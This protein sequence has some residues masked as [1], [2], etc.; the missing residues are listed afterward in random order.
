MEWQR[1]LE[2]F[3]P[4]NDGAI[5]VRGAHGGVHDICDW[6]TLTDQ[7]R[8][9]TYNLGARL[10]EL[11][12]DRLKFL[13]HQLHGNTD[14]WMYLRT[15]PVPRALESL[16]QVF[17][18]LYP[19]RDRHAELKPVAIVTRSRDEETLAP[20]QDHCR[21]FKFL[22][23]QFAARTAMRWNDGPEVQ[24]INERIGRYMPKESPRAMVDSSPSILGILDTI[25][26]TRAHGPEVRLPDV[27]YDPK[28]I[29]DLEAIAMEEWFSGYAESTEYRQLGVGSLG[30]DIVANMVKAPTAK[31]RKTNS[32]GIGGW[33]G[34]ESMKLGLRG[35]HDTTIAGTLTSLGVKLENWPPFTSH[36]AMELFSTREEGSPGPAITM[37]SILSRLW[38]VQRRDA[39]D[40]KTVAT[41]PTKRRRPL[42][43]WYVRVR[44]ND[45]PVV[46]P[47]C[48]KPG[49][50]LPGN[51]SF[52]TLA[53][54]KSIVDRFTPKDWRAECKVSNEVPAF[55]EKP[56]P[57]DG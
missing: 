37:T 25:N 40:G 48:T 49:N 30:G 13:P 36:I 6:G 44:Y 10:R 17:H 47:G 1:H 5:Q 27:F 43:G 50:H 46:I 54:F 12:I 32:P 24:Y 23:K 39:D 34:S 21:R 35:C 55:P 38:P 20:N 52:C 3:H 15:T 22:M 26:A 42:D 28:M 18:G 45:E 31:V 2:T 8:V 57:A 51:E 9:S 16:Q 56:E 53:A 11:Y 33:S 41:A 4:K 7:G 29:K 14:G 19:E